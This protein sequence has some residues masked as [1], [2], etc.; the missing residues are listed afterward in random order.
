MSDHKSPRWLRLLQPVMLAT[1]IGGR[2]TWHHRS[3][4][5]S[6]LP[7]SERVGFLCGFDTSHYEVNRIS[8]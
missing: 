7:L 2:V 5:C 1:F 8:G 3:A 4:G 6:F